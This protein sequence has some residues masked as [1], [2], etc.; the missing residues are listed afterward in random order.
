MTHMVTW[1][2]AMVGQSGLDMPAIPP[3]EVDPAAAWEVLADSFQAMLDDPAVDRPSKS[4]AGAASTSEKSHWR[5]ARRDRS[6]E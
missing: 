6:P 1:M 3:V 5:S 4:D 2:P